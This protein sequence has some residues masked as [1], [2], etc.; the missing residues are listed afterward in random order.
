MLLF[1]DVSAFECRQCFGDEDACN[2]ETA[3]FQVCSDGQNRCSGMTVQKDGKETRLYGCATQ[4]DCDSGD[5]SCK[6]V[7]G[8]NVRGICKTKCCNS[9]LCNSPPVKGTEK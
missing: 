9:T 5:V 6:A 4:N 2:N 3:T 7:P 8:D 1:T